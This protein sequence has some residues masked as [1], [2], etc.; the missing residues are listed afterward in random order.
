MEW[1]YVFKKSIGSFIAIF[2]IILLWLLGILAIYHLLEQNGV[3]VPPWALIAIIGIMPYFLFYRQGAQV[4]R[5][6]ESRPLLHAFF[7][8]VI[9]TIP[10]IVAAV[11][12]DK[13]PTIFLSIPLPILAVV[14]A[15]RNADWDDE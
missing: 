11:V 6:V 12:Q 4:A 1:G 14:G 8:S 9:T 7:V 3:P 13:I 10:I 5:T 2:F 15:A